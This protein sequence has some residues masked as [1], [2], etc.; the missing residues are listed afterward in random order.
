LEEWDGESDIPRGKVIIGCVPRVGISFIPFL[1]NVFGAQTSDNTYHFGVSLG[2]GEV[3]NNR[4]SGVQ[5]ERLE[6]VFGGWSLYSLPGGHVYYGDYACYAPKEPQYEEDAVTA[7]PPEEPSTPLPPARIAPNPRSARQQ[8]RIGAAGCGCGLTGLAIILAFVGLNFIPGLAF[9]LPTGPLALT[10]TSTPMP[11]PTPSVTP[12]IAE[13]ST[14]TATATDSPIPT[15]TLDPSASGQSF[16]DP[17]GDSQV[18]DDAGNFPGISLPHD[19]SDI[20]EVRAMWITENDQSFLVF[21]IFR[22]KSERSDSSAI[23]V[24]LTIGEDTLI[25]FLVWEDHEGEVTQHV[26]GEEDEITDSGVIFE[27]LNNGGQVHIKIPAEQVGEADSFI[28]QS[29]D[30]VNRE[31]DRGFDNTEYYPIPIP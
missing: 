1:D 5:R 13:T 23:Q 31:D 8:R 18:M 21:W 30:R 16:S 6:D 9:A 27:V 14:P 7:A 17:I 26:F 11:T 28:V 3:A 2:D 29:F 22:E 15:P 24:F 12:T 20:N 4:G 10:A 25:R 19:R